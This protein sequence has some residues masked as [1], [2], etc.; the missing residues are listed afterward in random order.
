MEEGSKNV[1]DNFKEGIDRAK[2]VMD[3]I[4]EK[5]SSIAGET[6]EHVVDFVE[7][8]KEKI[9]E[10]MADESVQNV[11][12]KATEMASETKESLEDMLEKGSEVFGEASEHIADF[13]EEAEG[14]VKEVIKKSKN[15]FQRL[16]KK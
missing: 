7:E 4:T 9:S 6:A 12:I 10:V 15:F 14:E 2:E 13:T 3:D 1:E 8:A 16:F 11:K 5:A